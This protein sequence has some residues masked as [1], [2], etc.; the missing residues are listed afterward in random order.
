MKRIREVI[1][2]LLASLDNVNKGASGKKVTALFI[3]IAYCY[4]HRFVDINNIGTV[5]TIDGGLISVLFGIGSYDKK[6]KANA[7]DEKL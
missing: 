6:I 5:L 7:T 4:S 3:T 2:W 1:E